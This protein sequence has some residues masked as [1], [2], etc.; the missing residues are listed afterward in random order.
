M[1]ISLDILIPTIE[2][3]EV[4][5]EGSTAYMRMSFY[6]KNGDLATPNTITYTLFD[7]STKQVINNR[8]DSTISPDTTIEIEL[9]PNDNV[10]INSLNIQETACVLITATYDSGKVMKELIS[11]HKYNLPT[12][13]T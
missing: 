4:V 7:L 11:Y 3:S 2:L 13:I 9:T 12:P 8:S 6:D 5:N 1:T 10:M